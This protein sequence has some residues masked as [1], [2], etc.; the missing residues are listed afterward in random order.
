MTKMPKDFACGVIAVRKES[1][2]F[3]FLIVD[4]AKGYWGFPK[5]HQD[6]GESEKDTAFREL[7]EETG[8][9]DVGL[10][11]KKILC[12]YIF[13]YKGE[14]SDK[15]VVFFLGFAR[16]SRIDIPKEFSDE[17]KEAKWASFEE[18]YKLLDF[19]PTQKVLEEANGYLSKKF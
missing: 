4:S 18:A 1:D 6:V 12:N 17:I 2:K 11:D 16:D 14:K 19:A 15:D 7:Y 8:I 3:L 5:G 13:E 9:R 10:T